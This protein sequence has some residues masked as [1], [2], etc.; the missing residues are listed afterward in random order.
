M[1]AKINTELA[2]PAGVTVTVS[3]PSVTVKGPKGELT[4][5][6]PGPEVKVEGNKVMLAYKKATRKESAQ[7]YTTKSHIKNMMEGVITPF[8]YHMKICAS[9]FPM[10]VSVDNGKLL[11]KNYLG[12]KTPRIV[13]MK[14]NIDVKIKGQDITIESCDLE[15][16]GGMASDI[17]V[18][19]RRKG[20]RDNRVFQD[21][22]YITKKGGMNE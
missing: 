5:K 3:G 10:T 2:I 22:I 9:H 13:K 20:G 18:L 6:L 7:M 4:R 16:A 11:I 19:T 15:S 21:G 1:N 12:E 17:E 14:K 8:K